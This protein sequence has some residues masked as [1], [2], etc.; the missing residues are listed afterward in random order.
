MD[1]AKKKEA[2]IRVV[3]ADPKKEARVAT[4]HNELEAFRQEVGGYIE[5]VQTGLMDGNH[6]VIILCNDDAHIMNVPIN[7]R[8]F[9]SLLRGPLVVVASAPPNFVSLSEASAEE[10]RQLMAL[11]PTP[12]T[13]P[14]GA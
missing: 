1:M 7:A 5:T 4:I 3:I 12:T 8:K 6:E 11:V 9:T 13:A 14:A 2:I 10:F